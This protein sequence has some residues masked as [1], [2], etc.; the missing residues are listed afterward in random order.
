VGNVKK[1]FFLIPETE[2]Q[3]NKSTF[4]TEIAAAGKASVGGGKSLMSS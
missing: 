4:G 1:H 2:Q 3:K